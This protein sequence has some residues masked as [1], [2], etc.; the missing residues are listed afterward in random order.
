MAWTVTSTAAGVTR[1]EERLGDGLINAHAT[2]IQA[3]QAASFDNLLPRTVVARRSGTAQVV[4]AQTA[5]AVPT[6][7]QSL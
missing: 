2:D 4:S 6:G 3:V 7:G 1:L 5:A